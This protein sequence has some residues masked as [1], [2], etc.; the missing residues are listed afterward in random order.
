MAFGINRRVP[1]QNVSGVL[2]KL[3]LDSGADPNIASPRGWTPLT[4]LVYFWASGPNGSED[5]VG[6]GET[7]R[8]IVCALLKSGARLDS[9]RG[10]NGILR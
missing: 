4:Y 2:I 8:P 1:L 5:F 9:V 10:D 7:V 6:P 3:L